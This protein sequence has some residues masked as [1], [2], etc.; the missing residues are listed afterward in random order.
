MFDHSPSRRVPGYSSQISVL[1]EV[2]FSE[3][4]HN[5]SCL[6]IFAVMLEASAKNV[7]LQ[8]FMKAVKVGVK[9][10]NH[11]IASM[12]SF[13]AMHGKPKREVEMV[14]V[15][16]EDMV[17]AAERAALQRITDVMLDWN[18]DKVSRDNALSEIREETLQTLIVSDTEP[19]FVLIEDSVAPFDLQCLFVSN[20]S[21]ER[22]DG[23]S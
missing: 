14:N 9:E 2:F 23:S 11:L 1:T 13:I 7:F 15:P 17:A 4:K 12:K 20:D 5:I 18:H 3:I 6:F 8:D 21:R 16:S 22:T 19:H 10:A